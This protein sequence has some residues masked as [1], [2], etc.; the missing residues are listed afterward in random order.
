MVPSAA[1]V[2]LTTLDLIY[3]VETYPTENKKIVARRQGM[4]AGGPAT[5]AAAAFASLGGRS[6]LI[7][8]KGQTAASYMILNDLSK[9]LVEI[10]DLAGD[11]FVPSISSIAVSEAT[12][13]RT[14]VSTNAT[15]TSPQGSGFLPAML[16]DVSLVLVDGHN[17][18]LCIEAAKCASEAGIHVV[19]DGGSWKTGT[20]NLLRHVDTAICSEDFVPPHLTSPSVD[21]ILSY[22][23]QLV[24]RAAL[25]RGARPVLFREGP[26]H[27]EV[28]VPGTEVVDTLGAGDIYHGA[29]CYYHLMK[30]G[31]PFA[32]LLAEAAKV[33]SLSCAHFGPR[34]WATQ[35]HRARTSAPEGGSG[36]RS[37]YVV[38][39]EP[40]QS[41]GT[42]PERGGLRH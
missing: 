22:L 17:L 4:Y 20:E 38:P 30:P 1:F 25:T 29:F 36:D 34:E 35:Y 39:L 12:G 42:P 9:L 32:E 2:G 41:P 21:T 6:R 5:N 40:H 18:D 33:A 23:S 8:A 10:V 14:V 24:R 13:S 37:D 27:G 28:P 7:S 3:S 19:F 16:D 31:Q 26:L 11:D 15:T